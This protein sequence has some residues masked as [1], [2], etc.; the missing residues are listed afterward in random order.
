MAAVRVTY[1]TCFTHTCPLRGLVKMLMLFRT[2]KLTGSEQQSISKISSSAARRRETRSPR[3]M[4]SHVPRR[5]HWYVNSSRLP[6]HSPA[7]P[8]DVK[9][10]SLQIILY[11]QFTE[12]LLCCLTKMNVF[13]HGWVFVFLLPLEPS[14]LL[15]KSS[16]NGPERRGLQTQVRGRTDVQTLIAAVETLNWPGAGDSWTELRMCGLFRLSMLW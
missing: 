10:R 14:A 13:A 16:G 6:P 11:T 7:W 1:C 2:L 3:P 8:I 15:C 4:E 5:A 9:S 12:D